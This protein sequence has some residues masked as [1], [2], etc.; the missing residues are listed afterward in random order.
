MP[1]PAPRVVI[2]GHVEWVTHAQGHLP[3]RGHIADLH[4]PWCEPAGGG[5]VA[6]AAAARLGA[7]V[8]LLTALG[9]DLTAAECR[10]VIEDRGV[11]VI[12][13][14]AT[15]SQTPVLTIIEPG[16]E[17]TIMVV[18]ARMQARASDLTGIDL[19][20][21]ADAVYY[22]GED[23]DLLLVARQARHLVVSGRRLADVAA[24]GIV[25][26]VIV[27]SASDPDESPACLPAELAPGA[28]VMTNGASGGS[29]ESRGAAVRRYAPA[30]QAAPIVDSY[31]CGDSFAAGL[32]VGL[33]RGLGIDD[34]VA[35]GAAAGGL[36]ATWRGGL[37]PP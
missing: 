24:A 19:L 17:R 1:Q 15:G 32:A 34:A 8:T 18:G 3:D 23:P 35:V 28:V 36:C 27:A 16:G 2:I 12:A 10:R 11:S 4:D 7:H 25:A 22:T 21:S 29:I 33:A 26:D 14:R 13:T 9:D 30:V 37:G 20:A 31:G 6:A 5:G